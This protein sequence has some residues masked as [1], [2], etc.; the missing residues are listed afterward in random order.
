MGST[1]KDTSVMDVWQLYRYLV[2][3]KTP[4]DD[5]KLAEVKLAKTAVLAPLRFVRRKDHF[6]PF[7]DLVWKNWLT[8]NISTTY[9]DYKSPQLLHAH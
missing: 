2:Y 7:A 5:V 4:T 3:L 1:K 6:I 9:W 8:P